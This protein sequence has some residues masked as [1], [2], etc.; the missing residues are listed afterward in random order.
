MTEEKNGCLIFDGYTIIKDSLDCVPMDGKFVINTISPNSY[1]ISVKD[2]DMNDALKGADYLD[3]D[4][5]YFG[6]LPW[7]RDGKKAKRITGWDCFVY[8]AD[9]L[10]K[11]SGKMFLLGSTEKTLSLMKARLA[12]EYPNVKVE[13][14]S[15]PYKPVFS[16]EDNK[17]MY[18]AINK[19]EPDVLIIGMTA[20]KQEKWAY[21]N[22]SFCNFHVSIAVGNVFD[23][24][25]GNT[26]RPNVFWQKI[27]M[28]WLVRI[29]YRPEIFRRNIGNQMRFFR[30]LTL[31]LLHVR[32]F[33]NNT[34]PL[35][36]RKDE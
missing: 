13:T 23:W 34:P 21:Q 4:G 25:A 3:L 8:Y 6:W 27:G 33:S 19:F 11:T 5:V 14:Y 30:H 10:N 32:P 1:G 16:D 36:P 17:K 31:D 35:R 29:F 9:K 28:E 26:K 22:K 15:P 18:E 24:Y 2:Q 20:P 7:F 12:K